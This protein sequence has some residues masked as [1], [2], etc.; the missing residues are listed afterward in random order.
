MPHHQERRFLPYTPEQL[1][2]LVAG[3]EYYPQFLPWCKAA[4]VLDRREDSV[5]A[6]LIIGYKMFQ[7]TFRSVVLLDPPSSITVK[8]HSGPLS[9]LSNQWSFARG[10]KGGCDLSFDV[11]FDF[12]SPLLKTIMAG[13]FDKALT[14]M[15]A[16]FEARAKEL[17][18]KAS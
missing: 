5:T 8:Y 2:N 12:R 6:D 15:V 18:G 4:R 3:I 16:A 9:H 7:E 1:F 14:K 17:Y 10:S 11:N 13:F